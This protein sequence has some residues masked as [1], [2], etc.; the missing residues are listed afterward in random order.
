MK[1]RH[2]R[3]FVV[4]LPALLVACGGSVIPSST[5]S[6]DDGGSG[7]PDAGMPNAPAIA[8]A[9]AALSGRSFR[10][11]AIEI[12]GYPPAMGPS[13]YKEIVVG[14]LLR[15]C[16]GADTAVVACQCTNPNF[17]SVNDI[18]P[19]GMPTDHCNGT[20]V[21]GSGTYSFD[22]SGMLRVRGF[23]DQ[24][25]LMWAV[26]P[27]NRWYGSHAETSGTVTTT[28]N[29]VYVEDLCGLGQALLEPIAG[30]SQ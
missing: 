15:V 26:S 20:L 11:K 10:V 9:T 6:T 25:S 5:A 19:G 28:S 13:N 27:D 17:A 21:C 29:G 18:Q 30:C 22:D 24:S 2:R 14:D 16:F 8:A 12:G 4:I 3:A 7:T 23:T 1:T